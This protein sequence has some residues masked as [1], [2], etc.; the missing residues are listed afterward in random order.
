M[1]EVSDPPGMITHRCKNE[2]G[3]GLRTNGIYAERRKTG[4]RFSGRPKQRQQRQQKEAAQ[5]EQGAARAGR[6]PRVGREQRDR[7]IHA[8]GPRPNH[9]DG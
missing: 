1:V 7:V 9:G 6:S 8:E 3:R 5:R 2:V 4:S